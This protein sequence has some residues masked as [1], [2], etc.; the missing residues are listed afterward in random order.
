MEFILKPLFYRSNNVNQ[1]NCLYRLYTN[2]ANYSLF[3]LVLED[4]KFF[5]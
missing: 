4:S 2:V 3:E 5:D 1:I